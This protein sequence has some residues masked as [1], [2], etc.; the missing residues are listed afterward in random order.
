MATSSSWPAWSRTEARSPRMQ[1]CGKSAMR[2]ASSSASARARPG[3]TR[4]LASP[5]AYAS[6]AGTGRPVRIRSMARLSPMSRGRRTVPPSMRGTPQRR[7]NT[8]NTASSSATRR[9]HQS[10]SSRP[11]ATACPLTAAITGLD[12][13]RRVGP[14]GPSPSSA[15][16]LPRSVPM[17]LRSA[18]AQNVPPSP[19]S[20]ATRAD[21]SASNSLK[22]AASSAAVGPSTA[23]RT[24]GRDSTTVVTCPRR[25]TR[26]GIRTLLSDRHWVMPSLA[27]RPRPSR[28]PP[29]RIE[30]FC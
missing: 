10:A 7:Q 9:S 15:T 27:R 29:P 6:G 25:S 3:G 28:T 11:P 13:R 21:S 1:A 24:S 18:P 14:I 4:R 19:Q 12:S 2:S 26:T 17:A 20:T 5:I 30:P 22:A 8:P 23:L 16:R